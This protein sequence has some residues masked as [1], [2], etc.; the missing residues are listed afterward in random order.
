MMCLLPNIDRTAKTL[1]TLRY[2]TRG[3]SRK[4]ALV[5]TFLKFSPG[6]LCFR[7]I[8]PSDRLGKALLLLGAPFRHPSSDPEGS[9]LSSTMFHAIVPITHIGRTSMLPPIRDRTMVALSTG[10]NK[11]ACM[12]R[13]ETWK[14]SR[15]IRV[16]FGVLTAFGPFQEHPQPRFVMPGE[17]A[18]LEVFCFFFGRSASCA[19]ASLPASSISASL[20]PEP[21]S[22]SESNSSPTSDSDSVWKSS[23]TL[24]SSSSALPRFATPPSSLEARSSSCSAAARIAPD[25]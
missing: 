16:M 1:I 11:R 20:S 13:I 8:P 3:T 24:S 23:S 15:S 17:A 14:S 12:Q 10:R 4:L 9:F 25:Y 22:W 5:A 19:P 21:L 2:R 6:L 18:Q 7:V